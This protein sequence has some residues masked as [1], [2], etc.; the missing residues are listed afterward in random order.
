MCETPVLH[1]KVVFV[2]PEGAED[3]AEAPSQTLEELQGEF[4]MRKRREAES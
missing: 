4:E 1:I 3:D 2:S